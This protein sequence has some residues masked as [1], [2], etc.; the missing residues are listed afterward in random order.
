MYPFIEAENTSAT[1]GVK[2]ACE[3]LKVFRAVTCMPVTPGPPRSPIRPGSM[4]GWLSG[5]PL[6]GRQA[7]SLD[8]QVLAGRQAA[9]RGTQDLEP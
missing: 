9:K 1:G 5:F 7:A 4:A 6:A 8:K 2:R 3:L